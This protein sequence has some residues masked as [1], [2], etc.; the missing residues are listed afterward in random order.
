M[1]RWFFGF[2][3]CLIFVHSWAG[4]TEAA[5]PLYLNG[6]MGPKAGYMPPPGLYIRNDI[7]HH[8]GHVKANVL[9]GRV[10]AKSNAKISLDVLNLTYVSSATLLGANWGWC[11]VIPAGRANVHADV[12]ISVPR[13]CF[14]P[15]PTLSTDTITK[16]K[17]QVAHG[18]ADVMVVPF[19][20]GWHAPSYDLHFVAFQGLFLPTGGYKK[21][22]IA[23][24]GQNHFASETDV[25]FTWLN[26]KS[27]TEVSAIT[28]LTINF[29]NHKIHYRSGT[30]WHT[31]FFAGQYLTPK[32][33]VGISGYWFYQLNPDS[34]TGSKALGGFR[35]QVLGLGPS[36]S[37]EFSVCGHPVIANARYFKETHARNYLKGE[38]FYLT[39]SIPI[40]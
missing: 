11:A 16:S 15:L 35:G 31:D 27:G 3:L 7:Y 9:G 38:T 8:P 10:S 22:D 24:M 6:Y 2:V 17:H 20:L 23:N 39:V 32:L 26:P 5:F 12:S 34:G 29:T 13:V 14:N 28:G 33:Q 36:I 4:A 30:G 21:G 40:P 1:L 19:M 18:L 37:Y 25:G